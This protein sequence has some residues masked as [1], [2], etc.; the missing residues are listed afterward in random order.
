MG[1]EL[2]GNLALGVAYAVPRDSI[3]GHTVCPIGSAQN[4]WGH[5]GGTEELQAVSSLALCTYFGS[6]EFSHEGII[7]HQIIFFPEVFPFTLRV[8][9][10]SRNHNDPD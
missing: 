2:V 8:C 4:E 1:L 7:R 9:L 10:L 6:W 5:R 3:R